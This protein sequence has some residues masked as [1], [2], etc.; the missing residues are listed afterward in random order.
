MKEIKNEYAVDNMIQSLRN[1]KTY[2]SYL[3][4]SRNEVEEEIDKMQE[5]LRVFLINHAIIPGLVR[6]LQEFAEKL[7]NALHSIGDG[8]TS[9]EDVCAKIDIKIVDQAQDYYYFDT[10][11]GLF[12]GVIW[13]DERNDCFDIL[14]NEYKIWDEE[15]ETWRW[16]YDAKEDKVVERF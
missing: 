12:R 3:D 14:P 15:S 16:M 11:D 10:A 6:Q 1:A 7:Q 8:Y 13:F 9:F 5:Q 4:T 2:A